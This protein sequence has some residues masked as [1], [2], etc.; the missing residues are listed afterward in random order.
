MLS[1]WKLKH[2]ELAAAVAL[3]LALLHGLREIPCL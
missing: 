2:T 3:I 1:S